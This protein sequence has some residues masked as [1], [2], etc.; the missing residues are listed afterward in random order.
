MHPRVLLIWR[1]LTPAQ[2]RRTNTDYAISFSVPSQ[3][4]FA[5]GHLAFFLLQF[6]YSA[7][8]TYITNHYDYDVNRQPQLRGLAYHLSPGQAYG[9]AFFSYIEDVYEA[10]VADVPLYPRYRSNPTS[11][12]PLT[13]WPA[14]DSV[15]L[16]ERNVLRCYYDSTWVQ[17]A[18][19]HIFLLIILAAHLPMLRMQLHRRLNF[20]FVTVYPYS[21]PQP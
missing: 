11:G 2:R 17:I 20:V 8:R 9:I 1:K 13:T 15:L 10:A 19:H 6:T 21:T 7:I 16:E 5:A 3:R 4:P 18:R 12:L 14:H